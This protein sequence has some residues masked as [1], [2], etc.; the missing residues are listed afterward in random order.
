MPSVCI[1]YDQ[2]HSS[3]TKNPHGNISVL[4][5]FLGRFKHQFQTQIYEAWQS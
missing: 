2:F 4:L 5:L 1:P 3:A